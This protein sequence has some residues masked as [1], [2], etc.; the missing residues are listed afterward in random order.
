MIAQLQC[1]KLTRRWGPSTFMTFMKKH[2]LDL[3]EILGILGTEDSPLLEGVWWE[4]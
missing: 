1:P 4:K 3:A 2:V